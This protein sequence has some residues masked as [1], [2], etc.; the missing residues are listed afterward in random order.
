MTN[1]TEPTTEPTEGAEF[2]PGGKRA[3][4]T[5]R[6]ARREAEK[7]LRAAEARVAEYEATELRADIAAEKGLTVE[8][9]DVLAG[10]TRDELEAH[11]DRLL[12]AFP[13]ATSKAPPSARPKPDLK[14]GNDPTAEPAGDAS[15]LADR[16]V[17]RTF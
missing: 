1:E 5:E 9:A 12:A 7:R 8:Q 13:A 4:D 14:G 3:L 10:S 2:T 16:I 17:G 15:A 11:A 6:K